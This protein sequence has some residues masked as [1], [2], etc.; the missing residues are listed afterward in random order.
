MLLSGSL[1]SKYGFECIAVSSVYDILPMCL[2]FVAVLFVFKTRINVLSC[3]T[4]M[5]A[6]LSFVLSQNLS[7][8]L[9]ANDDVTK[10][11]GIPLTR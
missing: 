1:V 3:G 6:Q 7:K 9:S 11:R 4:R 10:Y 8:N 5:W 2:S